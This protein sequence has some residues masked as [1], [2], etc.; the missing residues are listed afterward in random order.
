VLVILAIWEAEIGRTAIP[1][2]LK[3]KFSQDLILMERKVGMGA[4]AFP[5]SNGR[6]CKIGGLW[7]RLAWAKS[8]TLSPK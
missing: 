8:E 3:Q 4:H 1:G 5:S 2:Q 7:S 6:K